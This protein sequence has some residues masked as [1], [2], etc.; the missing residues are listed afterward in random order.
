MTEPFCPNCGGD[1]YDQLAR[2]ARVWTA[3]VALLPR[4]ERPTDAEL[5]TAFSG[6]LRLDALFADH[7]DCPW[8]PQHHRCPPQAPPPSFGLPDPLAPRQTGDPA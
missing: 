6:A 3:A 8:N 7:P 1:W 5:K 2:F 4:G